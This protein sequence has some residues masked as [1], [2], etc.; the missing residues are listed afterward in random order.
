L[1]LAYV[2]IVCIIDGC[3]L[4]VRSK[5]QSLYHFVKKMTNI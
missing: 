1:T 5:Q 4:G 2:I 3:K